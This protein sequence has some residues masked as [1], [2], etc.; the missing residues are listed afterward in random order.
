MS[1]PARAL[2]SDLPKGH[3][4]SEQT[5]DLTAE[6]VSRYLK[7]VGDANAVYV[8]TGLAPPLAV[9]A[10]ALGALLAAIELPDGLL[11]TGQEVEA[12]ARAPIGATFS[13]NGRVAQ[14]TERAGVIVSVIEFEV[15]PAGSADIALSG[16]TTVV[17][18][19]AG[20]ET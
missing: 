8:E 7:A 14:R 19:A 16:R 6:G 4:F 3:R 11:H 17:A 15:R 20:G 1:A 9:G 13:L 18:P 5:F 2:L 12:H 10:R